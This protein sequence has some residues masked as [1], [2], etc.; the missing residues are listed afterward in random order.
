MTLAT[1]PIWE[2]NMSKPVILIIYQDNCGLDMNNYI[3]V[4]DVDVPATGHMFMVDHL[5]WLQGY[6][7]ITA[8]LIIHDGFSV[9]QNLYI[10]WYTDFTDT[11]SHITVRFYIIYVQLCKVDNDN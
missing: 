10:L 8:R 3:P 2:P 11:N 1:E 5:Q 7:H 4:L 6:C 9:L